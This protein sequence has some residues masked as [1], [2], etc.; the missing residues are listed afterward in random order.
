MTFLLFSFH[1]LKLPDI[2][3]FPSISFDRL[4]Q[5][6]TMVDIFLVTLLNKT[7]LCMQSSER[8]IRICF[9]SVGKTST[10]HFDKQTFSIFNMQ[11]LY[12]TGDFL[13]K[14]RM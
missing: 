6:L 13:F 8:R 7:V 10:C 11:F 5:A 12:Y 2:R 4:K 14:N 3:K 1:L 9:P